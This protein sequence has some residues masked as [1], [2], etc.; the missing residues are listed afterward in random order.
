VSDV[1]RV[2]SSVERVVSDVDSVVSG[3]EV[4][5]CGVEGTQSLSLPVLTCITGGVGAA[6]GVNC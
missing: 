3:V 1:E 6:F 4:I 2:V 5:L